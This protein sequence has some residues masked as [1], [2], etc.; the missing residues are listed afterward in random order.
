MTAHLLLRLPPSRVQL[1]WLE[2]PGN[3]ADSLARPASAASLP[4]IVSS[5]EQDSV[6][7]ADSVQGC[8]VGQLKGLVCMQDGCAL[9]TCCL[10]WVLPSVTV[11][12][13]VRRSSAAE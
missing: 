1:C 13:F 9:L 8:Q 12:M 4:S 11:S 2:L 7:G 10:L 6:R 5:L 3:R